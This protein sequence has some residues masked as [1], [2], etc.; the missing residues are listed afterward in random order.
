MPGD[1]LERYT[2]HFSDTPWFFFNFVSG[3]SGKPIFAPVKIYEH[4]PG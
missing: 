1:D 4:A 3:V 2:G